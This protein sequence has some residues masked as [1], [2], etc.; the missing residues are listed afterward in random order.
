MQEEFLHF[1]W[2]FQLFSK[3]DLK[4]RSGKKLLVLDPGQHNSDAGP[5]F[6]NARLQLNELEWLGHVEIHTKASDW[7]RH[8]HQDD[9]NYN[10]VILHVVQ[11]DDQQIRINEEYLESL[12]LKGLIK[13]G[14]LDSYKSLIK[15]NKD[16]PCKRYFKEENQVPLRS[17]MDRLM[18]DRLERKSSEFLQTLEKKNGDWE[19]AIFQ[20][21][22]KGFGFKK[23][24]HGFEK[25]SEILG[26]KTIRQVN[27]DLMDLEALLFGTSGFLSVKGNK[28][29]AEL[30]ER[31]QFLQKKLSLSARVI[32]EAEWIFFRMRPGNFPTL[33]IAQLAAFLFE[34]SSLLSSILEF[35]A[36]RIAVDYFTSE[37]STYWRRHFHFKD[38][39]K[40]DSGGNIGRKSSE[41]LILNVV[42]PILFAFGKYNAKEEY[43]DRSILLVESLPAE[44][45]KITRMWRDLEVSIESGFDSQSLIELTN[46]YCSKKAC[47][48][49][50]VGAILVRDGIDP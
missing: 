20:T 16:I 30:K 4:T 34:K 23:N 43:I 11:E 13:I 36:N 40:D 47:L 44:N 45:N 38:T 3:S 50:N 41:S 33:R 26:W 49:C 21:L 17:M 7:Y 6:L 28:Y 9:P 29:S 2:Q 27:S 46:N 25:L 19:E 18:H 5:D 10:S 14:Y 22:A 15:E 31:Y 12:S 37:V 39:E 35:T 42:S 24:Q 1:I 8:G 48:K 32:D